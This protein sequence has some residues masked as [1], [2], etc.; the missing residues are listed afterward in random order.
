MPTMCGRRSCAAN[1][2]EACRSA[3]R[4][5]KSRCR[6]V[7]KEE[8]AEF[9]VQAASGAVPGCHAAHRP[10]CFEARKKDV[11]ALR[12][13]FQSCDEGLRL[14]MALPDVAVRE[15]IT[16]QS[17]DLGAAATRSRSTIR[18]V[19]HLTPPDVTRR[20][21]RCSPCAAR[22]SPPATRPPS[23]RSATKCSTSDIRRCRRSFSNNC[24]IR[25]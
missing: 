16:R 12:A 13:R 7:N 15:T 10:R 1:S 22:R 17:A 24:A 25:R 18:A 21:S 6:R 11:E 3:R 9:R 23:A 8:P 4:K 14:A 5:S 2:R 19:G 20:A